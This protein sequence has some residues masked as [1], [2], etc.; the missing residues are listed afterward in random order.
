MIS[1]YVHVL[2]VWLSMSPDKQ[3]YC[4]PREELIRDNLEEGEKKR[5]GTVI[6]WHGTEMDFNN[7]QK[8]V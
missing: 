1:I 2:L 6:S 4:E 3:G 5:K 7:E 8:K